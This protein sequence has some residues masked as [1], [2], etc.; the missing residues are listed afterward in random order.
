[1][2]CI[3]LTKK[4]QEHQSKLRLMEPNACT[5]SLHRLAQLVNV[6]HMQASRREEAA[7]QHGMWS[8]ILHSM[9]TC[10]KPRNPWMSRRFL[11]TLGR[12]H[13]S[14]PVLHSSAL[15]LPAPSMYSC[16]NALWRCLEGASKMRTSMSTWKVLGRC[17]QN[18]IKYEYMEGVG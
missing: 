6:M 18:A 15:S 9:K 17:V 12:V 8:C 13:G 3:L 5:S 1:M 7:I 10:A 14:M 16:L 4:M 2:A 11:C